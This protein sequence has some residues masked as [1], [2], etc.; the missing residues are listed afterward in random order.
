MLCIRQCLFPETRRGLNT[1]GTVKARTSGPV[2]LH[3]LTIDVSVANHVWVH[4]ARGRVVV[5]VV[6]DPSTTVIVTS[7]IA[8]AVVN[9]AVESN[10]RPPVTI[11]ENVT[12][13]AVA[14]IAW[15]PEK[16][17]PWRKHPFPRHPVIAVVVGPMAWNPD[18]T[19]PRA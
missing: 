13:S 2:I 14:P 11:V 16:T 3:N 18:V 9:P 7:V 6:T 4:P 12:A 17:D 15:R 8:I 5:E 1:A 19:G 10:R